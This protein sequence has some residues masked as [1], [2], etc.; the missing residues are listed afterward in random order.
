M[1]IGYDD[2]ALN[3]IEHTAFVHAQS[4]STQETDRT[5]VATLSCVTRM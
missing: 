1:H 3:R 2:P 4:L 5:H